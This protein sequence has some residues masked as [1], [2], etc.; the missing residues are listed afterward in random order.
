MKLKLI[1]F[2]LWLLSKLHI[3]EIP[4]A[5]SIRALTLDSQRDLMLESCIFSI[6]SAM[7]K[8]STNCD[9]WVDKY[10]ELIVNEIKERIYNRGYGVIQKETHSKTP[11]INISWSSD[12]MIEIYRALTY[13]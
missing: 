6:L 7:R 10:N 13:K 9:V 1:R 2:K 8:G 11:Y 12:N 5:N 4:D 3:H